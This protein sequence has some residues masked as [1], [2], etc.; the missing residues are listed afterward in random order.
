[1]LVDTLLHPSF[2]RRVQRTLTLEGATAG[3][4]CMHHGVADSAVR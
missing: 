3:H 1:M 4:A 2:V